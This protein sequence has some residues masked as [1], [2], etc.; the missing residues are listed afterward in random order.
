MRIH[1]IEKIKELKKL[2]KRGY[3]INELVVKLSI[4][5]TTVW[6]HIHNVPVSPKY[7]SIL[8][9]KCGGNSKRKQKNWEEARKLA[10]ELLRNPHREFAVIIAMLYWGEGTKK[11]CEFVNS[12]GK[13]IK[14]YL[15][16]LRNIFNIPEELISPTLRIF[17]GMDRKE[18]LDYW[19]NIT[20]ILENKFIVRLNDGGT[21]GRTKYG[22]CRII[23][24]KG[25]NTLKL[26]H[27][28]IEQISEEVINNFII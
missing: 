21:R 14:C 7:I 3:S 27:S 16:I 24:R 19:S 8:R 5:K 9:S 26:I 2:R 25:S 1:S 11:V 18:C 22:M 23:I 6:H 10:N 20:G 13:M 12:D 28:L 17:S 4:P 15:G